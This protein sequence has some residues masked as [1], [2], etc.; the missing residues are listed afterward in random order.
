MCYNQLFGSVISCTIYQIVRQ[1]EVF[2]SDT[3]KGKTWYGEIWNTSLLYEEC[4]IILLHI[5]FCNN[6]HF[7]MA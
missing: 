3:K 4:K 6:Y 5:I 7:Y 2:N 1:S